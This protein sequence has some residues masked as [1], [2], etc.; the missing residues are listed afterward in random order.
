M[1]YTTIADARTALLNSGLIDMIDG[2]QIDQ[3]VD[4]I[5]QLDLDIRSGDESVADAAVTTL[6]EGLHLNPSDCGL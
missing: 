2:G 5:W 1:K 4:L 6:L 3:A